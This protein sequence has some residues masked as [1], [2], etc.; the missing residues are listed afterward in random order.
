MFDT[1]HILR[2][3][4]ITNS[5]VILENGGR[6]PS[7]S[8][9][10]EYYATPPRCLTFLKND[11]R[12]NRFSIPV[13]SCKTNKDLFS[14]IVHICLLVNKLIR[15]CNKIGFTEHSEFEIFTKHR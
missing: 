6:I 3:F 14:K 13:R 12:Y 9:T 11:E 7:L 10:A 2:I 4:E 8:A 5:S 1:R 15:F